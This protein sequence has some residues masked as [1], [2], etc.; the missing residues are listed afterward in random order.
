MK[1]LEVFLVM[2]SLNHT[3]MVNTQKNKILRFVC[4]RV[5]VLHL[6]FYVVNSIHSI[7]FTFVVV[8]W[9]FPVN[10]RC[11]NFSHLREFEGWRIIGLTET[12]LSFVAIV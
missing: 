8:K 5:F 3:Y 12:G 2:S 6:F 9:F 7:H 10:T 1:T 11:G 4:R